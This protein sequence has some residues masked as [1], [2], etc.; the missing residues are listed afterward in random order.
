MA[1]DDDQEEL[2]RRAAAGDRAALEALLGRIQPSVLRRCARFLPCY[3]DAEEACQDVL[4][5]VARNIGKFR[6]DSKFSTWLHVIIANS[7]RQ[8]Y[9]SLKRRAVEQAHEAPPIDVPDARTTSVI[10]GSRLDLLDALD[11]LE[12]RNPDLVGPVVL[13]DICQLD[14]REIAEHLGIPEGT[15]KSRIHQGRVQV[16]EYL[17][18][19]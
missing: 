18:A 13:R 3:Q 4:L 12:T 9:R 19:G 10:A 1:R 7:S 5:Q 16:R 11:R 8:T 2:G 6:G 14:Y 15:V 17:G